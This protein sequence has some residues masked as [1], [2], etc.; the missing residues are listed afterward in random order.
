M[1]P[2]NTEADKNRL[3]Q[4]ATDCFRNNNLPQA[5]AYCRYLLSNREYDPKIYVLLGE[6]ARKLSLFEAAGNHFRDALALDNN[7]VDAIH[8][9]K[10]TKDI[11][12]E[13]YPGCKPDEKTRFLLIKAWGFGFWADIDH[14]LGQCLV[15]EL[16]NRIPV[17]YWGSNSLFRRKDTADAFT[18]YFEPVSEYSIDDLCNP[19]YSHFPPKWN[20]DNLGSENIN[21]WLG[22][23]SRMAGI[24]Y[25]TRQ[26]D[27]AV[28]D[29]HTYVKDIIPWIPA[30]NPL[31]G[32]DPQVVYRYLFSKYLH[33]QS[34]LKQAIRRAW[35]NN[36]KGKRA[37]AVH[38]RGSDKIYEDKNLFATHKLYHNAIA[39]LLEQEPDLH[40]FLL[41]DSSPILDE[42]TDTYGDNLIYTQCA[43][44]ADDV[45]VHLKEKD[46]QY[47]LGTEVLTD[48]F[49]ASAC[50]YFLGTGS[51][52]VS[53]T[54]LHTRDWAQGRC[55]LF[56]HNYLFGPHLYLHNR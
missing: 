46:D 49:L 52:N 37:L 40:I 30:N 43:R 7:N 50:E 54:V 32:Q 20:S 34:T 29:F 5:E 15:A 17:V 48:V 38:I 9:L 47:L 6:I 31:Y 23:D 27:V 53:T 3:I 56:G 2:G 41:T 1:N 22:P 36:L 16:T 10:A 13:Q 55:Q 11:T 12:R 14:V 39:S 8:G 42:Y 4:T 28:S 24:Y 44:S 21:K 33:V 26:E 51:S 35:E 18:L 45:G 25:L 19:D